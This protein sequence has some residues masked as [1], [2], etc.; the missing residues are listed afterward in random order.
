[1]EGGARPAP[2]SGKRKAVLSSENV[3]AESRHFPPPGRKEEGKKKKK[4]RKGSRNEQIGLLIV[5]YV[6]G[7]GEGEKT[8]LVF[9]FPFPGRR[10]KKKKKKKEKKGVPIHAPVEISGEGGRK[11]GGVHSF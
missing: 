10:E 7:G 1:M 8:G 4:E 6:R 5:S 9:L 2:P 11:K 3:L